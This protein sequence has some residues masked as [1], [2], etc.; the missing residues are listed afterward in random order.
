L[1]AQPMSL[2]DWGKL[3]QGSQDARLS[4]TI[5]QYVKQPWINRV[6]AVAG[7]WARPKYTV[8]YDKER[9]LRCADWKR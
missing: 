3:E 7:T 4:Q 2:D 9:V 6:H 1:K 8:W 5:R